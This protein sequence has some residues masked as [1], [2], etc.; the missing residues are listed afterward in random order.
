MLFRSSVEWVPR[1]E[2]AFADDISKM[3]ILEDSM[4]SK[5]FFGLLDGRCGSHT[6][7]LF[8]S[9]VNNQCAR[10]HALQFCRG[11]AGINAFGQLW[12]GGG[13]LLDQLS[14]QFEWESVKNFARAKG[15]G[16]YANSLVGVRSLVVAG[17]PGHQPLF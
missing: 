3:L 7:D 5:R 6:V 16:Y 12:T 10:F 15:V 9:S 17:V 1:E 11:A 4:L 14:L 8:S 2:N 13:E